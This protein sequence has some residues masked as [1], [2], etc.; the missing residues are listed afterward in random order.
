MEFVL[1]LALMALVV[2]VVATPLRRERTA[3]G[4]GEQAA[5]ASDAERRELEATR[6]AKLREIRDAELDRDTGKL[7]EEDFAR[8]DGELRAEAVQILRALDELGD[9]P[10]LPSAACTPCSGSSRSP[11]ASS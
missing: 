3:G 10:P 1:I 6:D 9:A 8:L 11:S 4:G 2:I 7:S 5:A